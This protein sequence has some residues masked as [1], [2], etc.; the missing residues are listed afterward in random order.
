[1]TQNRTALGPLKQ[2]SCEYFF[3]MYTGH[4]ALQ[5]QIFCLKHTE[6]QTRFTTTELK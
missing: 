2:S 1:M 6:E 5:N 3:Q 4:F